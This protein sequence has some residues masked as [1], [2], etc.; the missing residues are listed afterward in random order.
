MKV[1]DLLKKDGFQDFKLVAGSGGLNKEIVAVSVL[2]TPDGYQWMRGGEFLLSSG[3]VFN[4]KPEVFL[5]FLSNISDKN[6]SALGIKFDRFLP[7][8]P[9][10]AINRADKLGLPLIEIP[11]SYRWSDIIDVIYHRLIQEGQQHSSEKD[12]VGETLFTGKLVDVYELLSS[13]SAELQRM[14][15]AKVPQLSLYHAFYPNNAIKEINEREEST[16]ALLFQAG[17]G[18]LRLSQRGPLYIGIGTAKTVPPRR[19]AIFSISQ[20][21]PIE[22][23]IVLTSGEQIPSKRQENLMIRAISLLQALTLEN[24]LAHSETVAKRERFLEDLCLGFYDNPAI[25]TERAHELGIKLTFPALVIFEVSASGNDPCFWAP[26]PALSFHKENYWVIITDAK[27]VKK[28]RL[29]TLAKEKDLWFLVSS[30]AYEPLEIHRSY[31]EVKHVLEWVRNFDTPLPSG[32]YHSYESTLYAVLLN[33][34]KLPESE[35]LWKRYWK[36]LLDVKPGRR[37]VTALQLVNSLIK[38]DFNAKLTAEDL[39]LH[40]NTVRNYLSELEDILHLDLK[41]NRHRLALVLAYFVDHFRESH[42]DRLEV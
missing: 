20:D 3:F 15:I 11:V 17:K 1:A 18:D 27:E 42:H 25:I 9:R 21:T 12:N 24:T 33:L 23:G 10:E 40:Y 7:K 22:L 29:Q 31:K 26:L 6:I 35:S 39:H 34:R 2:D 16:A 13:L 32:V 4:Q 5:D 14:V 8:L 19:V 30:N 36:P 38:C 37:A 28:E 41:N